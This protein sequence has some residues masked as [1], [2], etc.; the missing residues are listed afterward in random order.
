MFTTQSARSSALLSQ[1]DL[2]GG[3]HNRDGRYVIPLPGEGLT[4]RLTVLRFLK[5]RGTDEKLWL[6]VTFLA[7]TNEKTGTSE[8][9]DI[10]YIG[11]MDS[12]LTLRLYDQEF[13]EIPLLDEAVR[14]ERKALLSHA[15]YI[16]M[17]KRKS[18]ITITAVALPSDLPFGCH[19]VHGR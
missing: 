4:L 1:P 13:E 19:R 14:D 11:C 7:Y 2:H 15:G 6:S 12:F 10:L 16:Y 17:V 18:I 8:I 5:Q 9:G 3:C